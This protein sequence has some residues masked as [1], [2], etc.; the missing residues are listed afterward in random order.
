MA[1]TAT[2]H[3][4]AAYADAYPVVLFFILAY[5][6]SGAVWIPG[7]LVLQGTS[8]QIAHYLGAFGPMIAAICVIRLRGGS[9]AAWFIGLFKWRVALKWY[10]FALLFPAFLVAVMSGLYVALGYTLEWDLLP[11]RLALYA[12]TLVMMALI[13]G[14]NEEPGWRG[15]ALPHLLKSYSPVLTTAMLG[16]VWALWHW[17]IL[18]S[19]PEIMAGAMPVSAIAALVG[20]TLISIAVHA[21]WYTWLWQHTGSVLL[22]ILLHASYNTANG[23]LLLVGVE[24]LSGP[25]YETLLLLMTSVLIASV[26]I[27]LIATRG[28]LGAQ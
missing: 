15:F 16:V 24:A 28:R 17:P 23:Q 2:P 26:V 22:C 18:L 14:G 20:V 3:R 4:L 12:P 5:A 21:F 9:V 19:N 13:G 1:H 25:A 7:A 11:Q 27:L 10:A 8:A 6:L